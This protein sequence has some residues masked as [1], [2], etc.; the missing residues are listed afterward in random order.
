[1]L[2]GAKPAAANRGARRLPL[3]MQMKILEASPSDQP[4]VMEIAQIL[5][6]IITKIE[7]GDDQQEMKRHMQKYVS[8]KTQRKQEEEERLKKAQDE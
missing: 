7:H 1:M 3:S 8:R 4:I 6:E 5:N 2:K